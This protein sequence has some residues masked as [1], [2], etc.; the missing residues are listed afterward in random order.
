MSIYANENIFD[1]GRETG[2]LVM[3]FGLLY[4]LQKSHLWVFCTTEL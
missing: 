1:D 2:G 3:L 4:K